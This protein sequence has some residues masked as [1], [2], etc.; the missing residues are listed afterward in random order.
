MERANQALETWQWAASPCTLSGCYALDSLERFS[1]WHRLINRG[2]KACDALPG[3]HAQDADR[4]LSF[5]AHL[6]RIIWSA[7]GL[8]NSDGSLPAHLS[9]TCLRGGGG[10]RFS[11]PHYWL[12]L[13]RSKSR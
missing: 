6:R 4:C 1:L 9:E 8:D 13:H 11:I 12:L 10:A 3:S 5:A 7:V 2:M